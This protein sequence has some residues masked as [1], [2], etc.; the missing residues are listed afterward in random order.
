MNKPKHWVRVLFLVIIAVLSGWSVVELNRYREAKQQLAACE[1]VYR[2]VE[3]KLAEA[4]AR[5][6]SA[7]P[8]QATEVR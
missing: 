4:K 1:Q 6:A 2:G 7:N 5:Y 8:T 3:T